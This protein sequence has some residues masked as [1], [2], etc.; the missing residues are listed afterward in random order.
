MRSENRKQNRFSP[1]W[2]ETHTRLLLLSFCSTAA[3]KTCFFNTQHFTA[4]A[5][6]RLTGHGSPQNLERVCSTKLRVLA[7]KFEGR[8]WSVSRSRLGRGG[9]T[10]FCI[11]FLRYRTGGHFRSAKNRGA[12]HA[13]HVCSR[14]HFDKTLAK[15]KKRSR[16]F[17][18]TPGGKSLLLLHDLN[19]TRALLYSAVLSGLYCFKL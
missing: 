6:P 5:S 16:F 4:A 2:R 8:R 14:W 18:T 3:K 15:K 13:F 9:L 17:K 12:C 10:Q 1:L 19:N 11:N 7:A